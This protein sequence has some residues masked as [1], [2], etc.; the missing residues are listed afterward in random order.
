M[1]NEVTAEQFFAWVAKRWEGRTDDKSLAIM[2]LG[3]C[4]EAG[5]VSEPIKKYIRGS[6]PV[7]VDDLRLELG[8]VLHYWSAIANFH[9]ITLESILAANVQKLEEREARKKIM[10]NAHKRDFAELTGVS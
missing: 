1:E 7:N 4:G 9:G 8:D 3:L 6:G 10:E 5:E 2:T